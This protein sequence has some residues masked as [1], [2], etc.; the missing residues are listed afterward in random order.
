MDKIKRKLTRINITDLILCILILMIFSRYI[1]LTKANVFRIIVSFFLLVQLLKLISGKYRE[2]IYANI[3]MTIIVI[4]SNMKILLLGEFSFSITYIIAHL[5]AQ[6]LIVYSIYISDIKFFEEKKLNIIKILLV[7]FLFYVLSYKFELDIFDM[8][9]I[10]Y[11]YI[12]FCVWISILLLSKERFKYHTKIQKKVQIITLLVILLIYIATM[13]FNEKGLFFEGNKLLAW[14]SILLILINEM[15]INA[16]S[17]DN[18]AIIIIKILCSFFVISSVNKLGWITSPYLT[19]FLLLFL[20]WQAITKIKI[21]SKKDNIDSIISYE[22][23]SKEFSD[24]LHD[25]ILQDVLNIKRCTE[26]EHKEE[27]V[28]NL[29]AKIRES[30]DFYS[31]HIFPKI[32]LKDNYKFLIKNIEERYKSKKIVVDFYCNDD[33]YLSNPYDIFI[34]KC[35][36]ECLNNIYKHTESIFVCIDLKIENQKILLTIEN[37]EGNFNSESLSNTNI[38]RGWSYIIASTEKFGG[39][40]KIHDGDVTKI[41]IELPMSGRVYFENI[42]N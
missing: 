4:S 3:I 39:T 22:E 7:A 37:D 35:I 14:D 42:I 18:N 5:I 29:I 34:Y 21:Y 26:K 38:G 27:L 36:R 13:I 10:L 30:M 6:L 12:Y 9:N 11:Y 17:R 31:P 15:N 23:E 16:K 8:L 2:I 25:E 28:D 32:S 1:V 33:L 20:V 19:I 24:F 41:E 40:Y